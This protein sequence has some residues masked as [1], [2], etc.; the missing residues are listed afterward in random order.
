M[1]LWKKCTATQE[2]LPDFSVEADRVWTRRWAALA[3]ARPVFTPNSKYL[4]LVVNCAHKVTRVVNVDGEFHRT[5]LCRFALLRMDLEKGLDVEVE[6]RTEWLDLAP[7]IYPRLLA[8]A[9]ER[10]LQGCIVHDVGTPFAVPSSTTA[11][12]SGGSGERHREEH[13]E[14]ENYRRGENEEDEDEEDEHEDGERR[15]TKERRNGEEEK[16]VLEN[17][18]KLMRMPGLAFNSVHSCPAEATYKAL[19]FGEASHPWF[20]SKQPMFSFHFSPSGRRVVLA[21]SPHS[22][23]VR[24]LVLDRG[25]PSSAAVSAP[26]S[27]NH[28]PLA[29]TASQPPSY[30]SV[31]VMDEKSGGGGRKR[32]TVFKCMPWRE[33]FATVTAFSSSGQWLAGASLLEDDG[34]CVCVRN[35]TV[36]EYFGEFAKQ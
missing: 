31:S 35:V 3:W 10:S 14:E 8:E 30:S 21:P 12:M 6:R 17:V 34:C 2:W 32:R 11:Y 19:S 15:M 25:Q 27:V 29:A 36:N 1:T 16:V 23:V 7:D 24:T 33:A 28:S 13:L 22:N 26:S 20:V 4:L 9:F 18:T 5:K